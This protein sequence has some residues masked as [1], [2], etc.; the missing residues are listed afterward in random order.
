M[1]NRRERENIRNISIFNHTC[2]ERQGIP[3]TYDGRAFTVPTHDQV[4]KIIF[5]QILN[6]GFT[7]VQRV[8]PSKA[9]AIIRVYQKLHHYYDNTFCYNLYGACCY[10]QKNGKWVTYNDIPIDY[11][12]C[13]IRH[14]VY[15]DSYIDFDCE[16]FDIYVEIS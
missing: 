10:T 12:N 6:L 11:S 15:Q 3:I 1:L 16:F 9:D 14:Y 5:S 2:W 7:K 8:E 4:R 13:L